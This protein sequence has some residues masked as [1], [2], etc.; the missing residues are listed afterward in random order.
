LSHKTKS[1]MSRR[2]VP[3]K[4]NCITYC[5]TMG[6]MLISEAIGINWSGTSLSLT[7]MEALFSAGQ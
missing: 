1:V 5:G 2:I 6:A 3:N 4:V 7:E